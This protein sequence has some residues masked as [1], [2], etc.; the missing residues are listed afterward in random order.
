MSASPDWWHQR[1][2]LQIATLL[3]AVV[4]SRG[5]GVVNVAPMDLRLVPYDAVQPDIL[6]IRAE[7]MSILAED[8][9]VSGAPDLVV[10][11]LPP[12]SLAIDPVR[13]FALDANSGVP[14]YW[15]V[16]P[17]SRELLLLTLEAGRFVPL[18]VDDP[19]R[20]SSRVGARCVI[21]PAGLFAMLPE[22]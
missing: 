20:A 10:E 14:E 19:G 5:L 18:P 6:F 4:A 8:R 13:T 7:Q 2:V 15:I 11:I 3:E 16:D 9:R 22:Q 1:L 21:D 17:F 12:T